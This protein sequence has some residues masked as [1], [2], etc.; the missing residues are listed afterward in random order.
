MDIHTKLIYNALKAD[1]YP[2]FIGKKE[3][4]RITR[5]S[6]SAVDNYI[7]Q[8]YGI[9]DYKKMG[10]AKNAKVLFSLIDVAE[11]LAQTVKTA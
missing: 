1:G 4:A 7:K 5:V 11:Y 9:P 2:L 10:N 8:G 3:Y 6:T